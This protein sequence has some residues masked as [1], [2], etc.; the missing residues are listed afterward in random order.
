M[1]CLELLV[2]EEK[3]TGQRGPWTITT[4]GGCLGQPGRMAL[5]G[6]RYIIMQCSSLC[7]P[8]EMLKNHGVATSSPFDLHSWAQ[9]EK[10]LVICNMTNVL[11]YMV[12]PLQGEVLAGSTT[13]SS[14]TA[15]ASW[16][17]RW[18]SS[19][20]SYSRSSNRSSFGPRDE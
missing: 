6:M 9:S 3:M 20:P 11:G 7:S 1:E 5:A 19:S 14:L 13:V 10:L 2:D 15:T 18:T 4:T 8:L 16:A 17:R 12:A